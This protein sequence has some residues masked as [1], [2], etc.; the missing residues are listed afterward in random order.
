MTMAAILCMV[1]CTQPPADALT[2]EVQKLSGTWQ[3]VSSQSDGKD[4]TERSKGYRYV[5]EGQ[6]MKLQDRQG[7][8]IP[9]TDGKP[10]E[11]PCCSA[12]TS[13]SH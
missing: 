1:L 8:P 3:V 2:Q 9:R 13:S 12:T 7:K 5:F 4:Q 6:L 11:R 10:D